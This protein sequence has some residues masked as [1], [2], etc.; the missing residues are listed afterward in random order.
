M[1]V[2]LEVGSASQQ[3]LDEGP[4]ESVMTDSE[5]TYPKDEPSGSVRMT[6]V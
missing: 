6:S 5:T 1:Y 3:N 2:R 4:F